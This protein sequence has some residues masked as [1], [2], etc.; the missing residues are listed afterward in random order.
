FEACNPEADALM[1]PFEDKPEMLEVV[2]RSLG[3]APTGEDAA[4]STPPRSSNYP[5]GTEPPV[6]VVLLNAG[7]DVRGFTPCSTDGAGAGLEPLRLVRRKLV[8]LARGDPSP[9]HVV[10]ERRP[11]E[12]RGLQLGGP[13][14]TAGGRVPVAVG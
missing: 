7:W 2:P 14:R 11:A 10:R 3:V 9:E 1:L 13:G 5:N 6:D 4:A 12:H 8:L